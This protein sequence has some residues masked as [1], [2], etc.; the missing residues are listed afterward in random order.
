[1]D[2]VN[3]SKSDLMT[4]AEEA[5]IPP[6]KVDVLWQKLAGSL[7][8]TNKFDVSHVLYYIGA[9]IV[10]SSMAWF[11]GIGWE[12]FGG[13]GILV[14]SLIYMFIYLGIGNS[15]WQRPSLKVP[16]GLF[17]TIAVSLIPLAVYGIQR[18]TGWWGL[19]DP[20]T[21]QDFHT[22]VKGGWF[23]MEVAT[24]IGSCVALYFYRFPFLTAPLFFT[25]WYMS[26]DMTP[27]IFG[28]NE[29]L[30]EQRL[31]V[32]LVFGLVILIIA[33]IIDQRTKE[34]FAFW[35]YFFGML[36]FW[37]G[38]SLLQGDSELK[39]FL[40]CLINVALIF[41]AILLQRRVFLVFGA[42]GVFSYISTLFY[43]YFSESVL[44]PFILSLIGVLIV[45]L[46]ILYRKNQEK[47][48]QTFMD[49]LPAFIKSWLP[50]FRR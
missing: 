44:F 31:W 11:L 16:G 46:G 6:E 4:A 14:I 36:A 49:A 43:R 40:F 7:E 18:M 23:A 42:I 37:F 33:Y 32:S 17:I 20:G 27:I 41:I 30:W 8:N 38:L 24:I 10:I 45:F 29:F 22:W 12:Q 19:D 15:L 34:D 28:D 1:M 50:R 9:L 13:S 47:I 35:G 3:V 48:E 5:D 39:R 2:K 21:Y 25:L 26:M